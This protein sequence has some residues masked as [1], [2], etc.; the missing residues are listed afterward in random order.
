M[1]GMQKLG[2]E[3]LIRV[4]DV[5]TSS[6]VPVSDKWQVLLLLT[7]FPPKLRGLVGNIVYLE[8]FQCLA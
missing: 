2:I 1:F 8:I 5:Q 7:D 4:T 6:T 3:F